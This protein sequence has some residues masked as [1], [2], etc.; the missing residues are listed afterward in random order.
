MLGEIT[1]SALSSQ[2][3]PASSSIAR[4]IRCLVRMAGSVGRDRE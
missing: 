3:W 4:K 2:P 1:A